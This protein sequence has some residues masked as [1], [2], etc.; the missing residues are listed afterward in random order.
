MAVYLSVVPRR[1]P[2]GR[3]F[4]TFGRLAKGGEGNMTEAVK[5]GRE[6]ERLLA[7]LRFLAGEAVQR[8]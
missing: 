4:Q 1:Y 3:I 7:L 2:P 5:L 8:R 6:E